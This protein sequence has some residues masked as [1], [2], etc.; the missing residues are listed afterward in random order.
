MELDI[1]LSA[2]QVPVVLHDPSLDRTTDATGR[3]AALTLDRIREAD[4][5][6]RWRQQQREWRGTTV[7]IPTLDEVLE[8]FPGM[9]LILEIKTARASAAVRER[10]LKHRAAGRC[11]IG[12]SSSAAL[13]PFRQHP[14]R[15]GASRGELLRLLA[16][17]FM[18]RAPSRAPFDVLFVPCRYAAMEIPVRRFVDAGRPLRRPVHVWTVDDVSLAQRYWGEGASA[19]VTNRPGVMRAA[20]GDRHSSVPTSNRR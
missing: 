7:R 19:I 2:D 20:R 11:V 5:G 15:T 3:V 8:S 12:S 14:F 4:A 16:A 17:L 13:A 1:H 10:L 6:A 9:P 18:G